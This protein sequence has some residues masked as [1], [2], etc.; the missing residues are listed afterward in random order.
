MGVPDPS[1]QRSQVGAETQPTCDWR[2]NCKRS[3]AA[4]NMTVSVVRT[5]CG[6][7]AEKRQTIG[8]G[9]DE[10]AVE[11]VVRNLMNGIDLGYDLS[12]DGPATDSL[13]RR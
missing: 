10:E 12:R 2:G 6:A 5:A 4:E 8:V 1:L 7:G 9:S 13:I 11:A 3:G